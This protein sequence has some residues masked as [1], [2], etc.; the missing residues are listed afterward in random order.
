MK[1]FFYPTL[2]PYNFGGLEKQDYKSSRIIIFPVPYSSTT[3]WK[4]GTEEGP[5]AIIEA[6]RHIELYDLELKKDFRKIGIFT[7]KELEPSKE[8]PKETIFRIKKVVEKVLEDGKFP[9]ILGGEHSITVGAVLAFKEKFSNLSVLQIDAH[10]DLRD[11][12]EGTKYHQA[13]VMRRVRELNLPVTQAGIRSMSEEEAQY[14]KKEKIKNIFSAAALPIE[15]IISSLKENVYLTLD[16]DAI[17]PSIMPSVALPEP[18]GLEWDKISSLLEK[19]AKSRKI[20]GADVV[21]LSPIPGLDAPN[22][23][24]AKLIYKIIGYTR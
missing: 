16:L 3:Y 6:S 2:E 5:Q 4:S 10:S 8:S 21:E 23:L 20:V 22:F 12:Y 13:C 17:D 11:E 1:E 14:I 9:L 18:A 15:K 7:F 19:V 24:A